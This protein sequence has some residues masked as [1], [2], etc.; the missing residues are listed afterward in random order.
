MLQTLTE[1]LQHCTYSLPT[2]SDSDRREV[3]K[4]PDPKKQANYRF[5][6]GQI[7]SKPEGDL[8]DDVHTSWMYDYGKLE[9][10]HGYVEFH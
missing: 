5:Y 1:T 6:S 10:H 4:D 9:S 2:I 7:E 8:I 3:K